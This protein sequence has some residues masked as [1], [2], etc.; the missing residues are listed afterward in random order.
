MSRSKGF[1]KVA[2]RN[3]SPGS[4]PLHAAVDICDSL[5]RKQQSSRASEDADRRRKFVRTA[6]VAGSW[7]F[8][9][10]VRR[11]RVLGLE[12]E[13]PARAGGPR[14]KLGGPLLA[15]GPPSSTPPLRS[16]ERDMAH[17]HTLAS[18]RVLIRVSL[19]IQAVGIGALRGDEP[20]ALLHRVPVAA[21]HVEHPVAVPHV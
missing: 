20:E 12:V 9:A 11:W 4:G 10:G 5:T 15:G 8:R 21:R 18:E 17:L 13:P 2:V 1:W 16:S 14:C 7:R 3:Q 6:L 19:H